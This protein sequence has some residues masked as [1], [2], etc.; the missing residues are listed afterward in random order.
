MESPTSCV[1]TTSSSGESFALD[2]WIPVMELLFH[3][4]IS[5]AFEPFVDEIDLAKIALSCHFALDLLCYSSTRK[6]FTI[7]HD[8]TFGYH[9]PWSV[10]IHR[11]ITVRHSTPDGKDTTSG[12]T[13]APLPPDVPR[14]IPD[15]TVKALVDCLV[16]IIFVAATRTT[17][18]GVAQEPAGPRVTLALTGK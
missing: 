4:Q 7:M 15:D 9:C 17:V 3:E 8:A 2:M 10:L 6:V 14:D 16:I 18:I 5:G 1:S 11:F 13:E 12:G